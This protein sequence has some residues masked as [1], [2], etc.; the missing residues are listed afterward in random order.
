[1]ATDRERLLALLDALDGSETTLQRDM[2]RGEGRTGDWGIRGQKDRKGND[3]NVIYP[4]GSGLS[5]LF[6]G[7]RER[8]RTFVPTLEERQS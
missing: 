1:M 7:G 5:D 8:P 4:D 6:H 2:V 3:A